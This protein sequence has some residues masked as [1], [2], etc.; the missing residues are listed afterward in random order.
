MAIFIILA[1]ILGTLRIVLYLIRTRRWLGEEGRKYKNWLKVHKKNRS[2]NEYVEKKKKFILCRRCSLLCIIGII[3][4]SFASAMTAIA[5]ITNT[6]YLN[7]QITEKIFDK[8]KY[9][10]DPATYEVDQ[11]VN[12]VIE[13]EDE[14]AKGLFMNLKDEKVVNQITEDIIKFYYEEI[15]KQVSSLGA[16]IDP[17]LCQ[18]NEVIID[19]NKL[20][21]L[22]EEIKKYKYPTEV[23]VEIYKQ[24]YEIRKC[25]YSKESSSEN[26][27]QTGRVSDDIFHILYLKC[28]QNCTIE[29][30]KENNNTL[31]KTYQQEKYEIEIKKIG[32]DELYFYGSQA[33]LYYNESLK[34]LNVEETRNDVIF[35]MG[36]IF[37]KFYLLS[38]ILEQDNLETN[39]SNRIH[40]L[41]LANTFFELCKHY[42]TQDNT[43]RE[44]FSYYFA[45]NLYEVGFFATTEFKS[46]LWKKAKIYLQSYI[47]NTENKSLEE[48]NLNLVEDSKYRIKLIEQN[49]KRFD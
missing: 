3:F 37:W 27:Y 21:Q 14:K 29:N 6:P 12:T 20:S 38:D 36:M 15:S 47:K 46:E 17:T 16:G 22:D 7:T 5:A 45:C 30:I 28:M 33:I 25:A 23:P 44:L 35:K 34:N 32:A 26:A 39:Q 42:D 31:N 24:E 1:N 9:E 8:T 41:L 11:K 13:Y 4:L 19:Y 2:F 40:F 10:R 48:N 49:L 43:C 18:D